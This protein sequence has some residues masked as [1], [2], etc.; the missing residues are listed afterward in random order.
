[1]DSWLLNASNKHAPLKK[2]KLARRAD[3]HRWFSNELKTQKLALRQLERQWR[4]KYSL[5]EK[6][7]YIS[8]QKHYKKSILTAKAA[9]FSTRILN[10]NKSS[11]EIFTIINELSNPERI[12]PKATFSQ[13][14]CNSLNDYFI[15][16]IT[17]IKASIPKHSV[18]LD[19]SVL[20]KNSRTISCFPT[21]SNETFQDLLVKVKSG[22]PSDCCPPHILKDCLAIHPSPVLALLNQPLLSGIV[23]LAFKKAIVVTL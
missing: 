9:H 20:H 11:K 3:A 12:L 22:A 17:T 6:L 14:L 2:V 8:A 13:A 16:K 18:T 4:L 7:L 19:P 5:E 10:S 1:M 23:P 21:I 15:D